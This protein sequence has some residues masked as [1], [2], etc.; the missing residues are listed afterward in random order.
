M[1]NK[2][3][4]S[5]FIIALM[6]GILPY[7]ANAVFDCVYQGEFANSFC[8][9]NGNPIDYDVYD[10]NFNLIKSWEDVSH[11]WINENSEAY[12]SCYSISG[13][14]PFYEDIFYC[15]PNGLNP[16]YFHV[17]GL[18]IWYKIYSPVVDGVYLIDNPLPLQNGFFVNLEDNL[19][20]FS[21]GIGGVVKGS[22]GSI[23]FVLLVFMGT[24]LAFEVLY[25]IQSLIMSVGEKERR[26]FKT[27]KG[28]SKL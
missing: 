13:P 16:L 22:V 11:L 18:D 3:L 9:D 21:S 8:A 19:T 24:L 4:V 28:R 27:K 17:L 1:N 2:F 26:E 15:S 14:P 5:S 6:F 10:E 7:Q 23:W 20:N 12:G 25:Q